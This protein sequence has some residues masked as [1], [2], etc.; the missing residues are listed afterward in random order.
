MDMTRLSY[1][2]AA[3]ESGSFTAAAHACY[4]SQPN[5]SKQI[6]AL[7]AELDA[8]LFYR[9]NRSVRLT[10][11]G[12]YLYKEIKELPRQL[13]QIFQTTQALGRADGGQLTIGLLAGQVLNS[14]FIDRINRFETQYPELKFS[15]ERAGFT[16]LREALNSYRLDMIITLSFDIEPRPELEIE[17]LKHQGGALFISR[18]SPVQDFDDLSQAPFIT[19]SPEES[20]GGYQQLLRFG[21]QHGFEPNIV[22]LA[23]SLDSLLFYVE[24]G[25]G[26]SILDRNTRLENDRNIRVVPM[27]DSEASDLIA[28]WRRDNNNPHI[29]KMVDCLKNQ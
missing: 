29:R 10:Q 8:K 26:V 2:V 11:A 5:I 13:N 22:R 6:S 9:D 16:A 1:F 24:A 14:D 12:E 18:M 25:V 7:E 21:E 4:T 15:L 20:Y 23:N 19:I 17:T 27:P 28:V 3:A